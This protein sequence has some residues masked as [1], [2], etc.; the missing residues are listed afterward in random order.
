MARTVSI[1]VSFMILVFCC[2]ACGPPA[3]GVY[4]FPKQNK[5]SNMESNSTHQNKIDDVK[6]AQ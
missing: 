1:V 5:A 4:T 3:G 6:R 2:V